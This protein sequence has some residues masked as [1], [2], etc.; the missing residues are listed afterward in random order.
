MWSAP[1]QPLIHGRIN[2]T[3]SSTP[4]KGNS[5]V[6]LDTK[7]KEQLTIDFLPS[8]V[9]SWSS[10]DEP[11]KIKSVVMVALKATVSAAAFPMVVFPVVTKSAALIWPVAVRF[12]IPVISLLP[13]S[14][15]AFE[16]SAVPMLEISN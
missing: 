15:N 2:T 13:S 9:N 5:R 4:L 8:H 10:A 12:L 6:A 3:L 1:S 16:A 14:T 7:L 11:S